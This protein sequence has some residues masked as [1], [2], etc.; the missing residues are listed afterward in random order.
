MFIL[1]SQV[2]S[3][4]SSSVPRFYLFTYLF[5]SHLVLITFCVLANVYTYVVSPLFY[6]L[7]VLYV[8][9]CFSLANNA[10]L[11]RENIFIALALLKEPDVCSLFGVKCHTYKVNINVISMKLQPVL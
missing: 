9:A 7:S 3:T 8:C 2:Y 10:F 1:K 5:I 11:R 4:T 6:C